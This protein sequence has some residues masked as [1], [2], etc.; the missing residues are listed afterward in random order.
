MQ[1]NWTAR[2]KLK[3]N[4]D[5]TETLLHETTKLTYNYYPKLSIWER[6]TFPLCLLSVGNLGFIVTA[7]MT[8]DKQVTA[9]LFN[10]S[11]I[12]KAPSDMFPLNKLLTLM[13]MCLFY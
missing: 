4:D 13:P 1:N 10:M 6:P 11:S 12:T 3:L 2:N 9:S 5:E 7:D 8:L